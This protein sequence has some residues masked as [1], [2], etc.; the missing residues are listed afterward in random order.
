[1]IVIM[2]VQYYEGKEP[3]RRLSRHG[4]LADECRPRDDER[5]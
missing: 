4:Y 2:G 3:I 1:M 5:R